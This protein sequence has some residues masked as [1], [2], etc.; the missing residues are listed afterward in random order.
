MAALA[1]PAGAAEDIRDAEE[2]EVVVKSKPASAVRR[3]RGEEGEHEGERGRAGSHQEPSSSPNGGVP[4]ALESV[5]LGDPQ[6]TSNSDSDGS[7]SQTV[8]L[9]SSSS[10]A[11][12]SRGPGSGIESLRFNSR[13]DFTQT[14]TFRVGGKTCTVT[15]EEDRITW[16]PKKSAGGI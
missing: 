14:D 11:A 10:G 16:A 15:L 9:R 3:E 1:N 12:G 6:R 4:S 2:E 13:I 7:G 8:L 5:N